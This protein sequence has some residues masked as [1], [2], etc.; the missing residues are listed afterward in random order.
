MTNKKLKTKPHFIDPIKIP[1][2]FARLNSD[3][4]IYKKSYVDCS[5]C[6]NIDVSFSLRKYLSNAILNHPELLWDHWDSQDQNLTSKIAKLHGVD[7]SQVFIT[8][9]ALAGIE[10]CFKIFSKYN[11]NVGIIKPDWPGF[12]YFADFYR[13]NK[14]VF[15]VTNPPFNFAINGI[16]QFVNYNNLEMMILANP[17]PINGNYLDTE[18]LSQMLN[19][20]KQTL[21]IIDEADTINPDKQ[22]AHLVNGNDNVIFLGSLSKFY[23]L[24]GL[25][26]GYLVCPISLVEC[27][28]KTV[29]IAEVTSISLLAGNFVIDD[30]EYQKITQ[31]NV[32]KSIEIL[33]SKLKDTE[34][35]LSYSK[36]CFACFISSEKNDPVK[37]LENKN[38]KILSSQFFGI[39]KE[40]KGGRFNLSN[41]ENAEI[42]AQTLCDF[43]NAK[44]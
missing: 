3:L 12:E 1:T 32:K 43:V 6:E 44:S 31:L 36:D 9:G 23:G 42:V 28:K 41:P 8:S 30:L 35:K 40:I 37:I 11:S 29:S 7:R 15:D 17:T 13:T 20:S 14:F 22:S 26:I 27:F 18:F 33:E 39:P 2:E 10:Y 38:I 19:N 34:F 5:G 4:E 25:R 16:N 24:S 21:F